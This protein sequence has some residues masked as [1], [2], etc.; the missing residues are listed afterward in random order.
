MSK[1]AQRKAEEAE[2]LRKMYAQDDDTESSF[3]DSQDPTESVNGGNQDRTDKKEPLPES[4]SAGVRAAG[5]IC[6]T[7]PGARTA[8]TA[9]IFP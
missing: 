2:I 8:V 3:P 7:S 1:R 9:V 4:K 6:E 5:L